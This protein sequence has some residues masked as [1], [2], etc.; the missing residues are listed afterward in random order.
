[1][2]AYRC[3]PRPVWS[4]YGGFLLAAIGSAVGLGNIWRFPY[5][6]GQNGGGAFVLVYLACIVVVALPV[7]IAELLL[8]RRG[9]GSPIHA[10]AAVVTESGA[11]PR[12]RVL[13]WLGTVAGVLVLSYYSVIAGWAMAYVPKLA[14]GTFHGVQREAAAAA[15]AAFTGNAGAQVFWHTVFMA[16]TGAIVARGLQRGLEEAAKWMM[17]TL[18]VALVV[19][20]SYALWVGDAGAAMAFLF[21]LDFSKLTAQGV[22]IA[23]GH[24]F[25]S[26]GIGMGSMMV[27]G[28]YLPK[29]VALLP[30]SGIIVAADTA[31]AILAGMAIFPIVF[32]FGL[33]PAAGPGLI[34]ETLPIAFGQVPGGAAFGALFFLL[35]VC[36]ALTSSIAL[37]EPVTAY[38]M[39]R[40][41]WSR[42]KAAAA[43]AAAVWLLGLGTALSFNVWNTVTL[44]GK[45]F[46]DH[47]DFLT[48][49]VLLPLSALGIA[50]LTGWS[51]ARG[52]CRE[53]LGDGWRFTVWE[54]MTAVIA[55]LAMVVVMMDLLGMF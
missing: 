5:L 41:G 30:T 48:A 4:S 47:I 19:L 28:S 50:V 36:A 10:V 1:M 46:F 8:G 54:S 33:E 32:A 35:L 12:W 43:C 9:A 37:L 40:Y 39:E 15:F 49:N 45:T 7:L 42:R 26:V 53:E 52:V 3:E 34:F 18:L 51:L 38:C 14:S 17:L 2:P 29:S 20:V 21:N 31:V 24:A 44:G 11:A 16:T 6:A 55:P 27:Y 23:L 25:F 22:V 13:G